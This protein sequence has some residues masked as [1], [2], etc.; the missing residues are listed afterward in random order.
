MHFFFSFL[1]N[2]FQRNYF[3][4]IQFYEKTGVWK[5]AIDVL[6]LF[7]LYRFSFREFQFKNK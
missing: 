1:K 6:F 2:I 5:F 7:I 3:T 4:P